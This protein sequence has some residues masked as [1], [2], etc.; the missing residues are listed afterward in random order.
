MPLQAY[1][2]GTRTGLSVVDSFI[3]SLED[4]DPAGLAGL[5]RYSAIPCSKVTDDILPPCPAGAMDG[6]LVDAIGEGRCDWG[7]V[8]RSVDL[9]YAV[10]RFVAGQHRVV[11]VALLG[12]PG[13]SLGDGGYPT[14][15]YL[16]VTEQVGGMGGEPRSA[17]LNAS[18]VVYL[19]TGCFSTTADAQLAGL[20][21][22]YAANPT[23]AREFVLPPRE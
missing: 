7:W 22:S 1:P 16:V 18:G 20:L 23:G 4:S 13:R 21:S 19:N 9:R 10:A 15:A 14:A 2:K 3:R 12:P 11:A 6:T 17:F 8:P 5:L